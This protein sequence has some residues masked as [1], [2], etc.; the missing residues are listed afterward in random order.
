MIELLVVIGIVGLLAT[1]VIPVIGNVKESTN[2]TKSMSNLRQIGLLMNTYASDNN[3]R[4]PNTVSDSGEWWLDVVLEFAQYDR[5]RIKELV[6]CPVAGTD[7]NF[8]D[9]DLTV[10]SYGA[11]EYLLGRAPSG[12][13]GRN[14]PAYGVPRSAVARPSE[15]IMVATGAHALGNG[16]ATLTFWQPW[17]GHRSRPLDEPVPTPPN[18]T[19]SVGHMSYHL[20]GSVGVV[21]V[22][23]STELIPLG[24]VKWKH[25]LPLVN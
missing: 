12:E 9:P 16:G 18:P 21:K 24:E 17:G 25:Y 5:A 2:V 3:D 7:I 14:N 13:V 11:H 19:D 1:L 8:S 20:K 22:D 23:G 6:V 10:T 4:Y 15:Q